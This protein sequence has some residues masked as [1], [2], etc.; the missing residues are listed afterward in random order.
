ME[1]LWWPVALFI[2]ASVLAIG[3]AASLT[4]LACW[5]SRKPKPKPKPRTTQGQPKGNPRV[6]DNKIASQRDI[7][8]GGRSQCVRM[9]GSRQLLRCRRLCLAAMR[10]GRGCQGWARVLLQPSPLTRTSEA[11]L[12]CALLAVREEL[13]RSMLQMVIS[14]RQL[15]AWWAR[16]SRKAAASKNPT[17]NMELEFRSRVGGGEGKHGKHGCL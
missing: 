14:T 12:G 6:T 9:P 2:C 4:S 5:V 7:S 11:A 15:P 1:N 13:D 17:P 3:S 8:G 16:C 10:S